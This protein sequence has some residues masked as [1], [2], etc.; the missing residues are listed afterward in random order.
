MST[1]GKA[2]SCP[3][4]SGSDGGKAGGDEPLDGLSAA[5]SKA[6]PLVAHE[7]TMTRAAELSGVSVRTLQ[8]WQRN[9]VFHSAV[10]GGKE[11][12]SQA[13]GVSQKY[14]AMAVA[15]FVKVINDPAARPAPR[16]RR[17][18]R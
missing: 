4:L 6:V 3:D 16:C 2:K 13:V 1:S 9:P 7:P 10:L 11:A 15:T 17:G 18:R 8:R 12:Y 5:Q 14:A